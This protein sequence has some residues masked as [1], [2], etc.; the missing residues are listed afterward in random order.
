MQ[1]QTHEQLSAM[2]D[3]EASEFER[4]RLIERV[5]DDAELAA[6]WQRYHIAQ[7]VMTGKQLSSQLDFDLTASIRAAIDEQPEMVDQPMPEQTVSQPRQSWWKPMAS[8]AVA[9]SVTAVVI[10]GGQQYLAP[11]T[12]LSQPDFTL[13]NT[14]QPTA[15]VIQTQVSGSTLQRASENA[16]DERIIRYSEGLKKYIDQHNNLL[17]NPAMQWQASFI[18]AGFSAVNK[19]VT[20]D[21]QV[22]LYSNGEQSFSIFVEP[23]GKQSVAQG[24]AQSAGVVAV[25]KRYGDNFVTVV[26]DVALA[27]ADQVANSVAPLKQ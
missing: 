11:T 24:S 16:N 4:R 26:G 25:G 23:M 27:V 5:A 17:A 21:A 14:Q 6:K 20:A 8:M 22:Q 19:Q 15:G 12:D 2:M 13:T 10:L 1:D 18:P 9:A 7:D 3:G